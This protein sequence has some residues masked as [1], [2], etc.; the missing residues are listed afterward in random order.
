MGFRNPLTSLSADQ[1]TPGVLDPGVIAQAVRSA[2]TGARIELD[3]QGA[4]GSLRFYAGVSGESPATVTATSPGGVAGD[5]VLTIQGGTNAVTLP[6]SG[7]P[8]LSMF[9]AQD[10]GGTWRSRVSL[11]ADQLDLPAVIHAGPTAQ[12]MASGAVV[13]TIAAGS[14]SFALTLGPFPV[15]VRIFAQAGDWSTPW[16]PAVVAGVTGVI[17]AGVSGTVTVYYTG[18]AAGLARFNW[19]AIAQ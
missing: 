4:V 19:M 3:E 10:P 17:A 5:Q 9:S 6:P 1:I 12:F 14:G 13:P 7:A 2:D 16:Q 18:A 15:A 11:H 8:A